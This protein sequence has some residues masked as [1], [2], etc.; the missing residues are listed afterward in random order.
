MSSGLEVFHRTTW[1]TT[2]SATAAANATGIDSIRA[3]TAAARAGSSTAGPAIAAGVAP[4]NGA[5]STKVS[6]ASVPARTQTNV[7]RLRTGTPRSRARSVFS[8]AA[9][10]AVPA[11]DR[12]RNQASA[13]TT[14]GTT[15]ATS[16]W[17]PVRMTGPRVMVVEVRGVSNAP[18]MGDSTPKANLGMASS[19]PPSSCARPMVATVS[20]SRGACAKRRM[21]VSSTSPPSSAP[22]TSAH[23]IAAAYGQSQVR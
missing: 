20:T 23:T 3:T 9:R 1:S 4:R 15:A 8:A 5:F 7:V 21:T 14:T 16:R 19:S 13:P 11:S 6:A 18:R 10:I 22:P 17:S 2:P 12:R